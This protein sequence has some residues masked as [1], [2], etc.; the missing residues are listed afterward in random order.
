MQ[1]TEKVNCF[2]ECSQS[3]LP[4]VCHLSMQSAVTPSGFRTGNCAVLYEVQVEMEGLTDQQESPGGGGGQSDRGGRGVP[5]DQHQLLSG[6]D[7]RL[8]QTVH[9]PVSSGY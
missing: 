5:G 7:L 4:A 1:M 9:S 8:A 3:Q 2:I 6:G